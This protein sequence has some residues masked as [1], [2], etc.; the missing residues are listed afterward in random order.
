MFNEDEHIE[1]FHIVQVD[2]KK[3]DVKKFEC[4]DTLKLSKRTKQF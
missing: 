4:Y 1:N 3:V 2:V